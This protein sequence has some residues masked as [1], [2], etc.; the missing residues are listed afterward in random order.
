MAF[1]SLKATSS[2]CLRSASSFIFIC[3]MRR[4]CRTGVASSDPEPFGAAV[5]GAGVA[6]VAGVAGF[7]GFG[8]GL[9]FTFL[10][11]LPAV[12]R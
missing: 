8:F 7:C 9:R 5:V 12:K 10:P 1:I 2:K 6:G 11:F 4:E 3:A